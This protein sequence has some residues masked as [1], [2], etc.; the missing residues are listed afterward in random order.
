MGQ[1]RCF[2]FA[3]VDLGWWVQAS[4][5]LLCEWPGRTILNWCHFTQD[6]FSMCSRIVSLQRHWHWWRGG[7][8]AGRQALEGL[9]G[10]EMLS[11]LR[12]SCSIVDITR[13]TQSIPA[14]FRRPLFKRNLWTQCS[15]GGGSSVEERSVMGGWRGRIR[16]GGWE[17]IGSDVL[18]QMVRVA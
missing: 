8:R 12:S 7:A 17:R 16:Y 10:V 18:G 14:D 2:K 15:S 13:S 1:R 4:T 11:C 5:R 3:E 9:I 6:P